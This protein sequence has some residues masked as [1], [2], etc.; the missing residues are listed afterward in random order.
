MSDNPEIDL[1]NRSLTFYKK[2]LPA[3]LSIDEGKFV[4]ISGEVINGIFLEFESALYHGYK[5]YGT[6]NFIVKQILDKEPIEIVSHIVSL[7]HQVV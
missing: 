4:V 6:G 2:M 1:F 3:L 5:I 7:K